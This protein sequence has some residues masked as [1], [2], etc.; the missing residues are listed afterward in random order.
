M[1]RY[2]K[3]NVIARIASKLESAHG[4]RMYEAQEHAGDD[5]EVVPKEINFKARAEDMFEQAL[6]A[7]AEEQILKIW[8]I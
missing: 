3:E 2:S 1:S 6:N 8:E 7:A 4:R 5:A